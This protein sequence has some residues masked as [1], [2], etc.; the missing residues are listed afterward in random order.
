MRRA[1]VGIGMLTVLSVCLTSGPLARSATLPS[2]TATLTNPAPGATPSDPSTA[3]LP[4][5]SPPN[6]VTVVMNGD[7]LWHNTLWYGAKEDARRR[8]Q[9]GYDFAPLLAGLKPVVASV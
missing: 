3:R 2:P 8:G 5:N 9:G 6:T 4:S 7:L 1:A